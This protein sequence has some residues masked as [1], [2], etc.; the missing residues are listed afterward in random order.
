MRRTLAPTGF[1][2]LAAM[3]ALAPHEARAV[4]LESVW[5]EVATANPTLASRRA[6]VEA[7][8]HRVAPAGAWASPMV[9]IGALNV[10]TNGR[11]DMEPMTMKMLGVSQSVP[12]FGANRLRRSAAQAAASAESAGLEMANVELFAMAWA[13]YSDAYHAARLVSASRTHEIEMAQLVLAARARYRS[14]S[15]RLDDVLRAEAEQA[16]TLSDRAAYEGEWSGA[17]ARLAALMGRASALLADSLEALPSAPATG[18]LTA[19]LA[20]VDEHHPRLR[21]LRTQRDGYRLSARAARRM[22]WPDLQL[23]VSYGMREPIMGEAQ[24]NMWSAMLG[25][26]LPVFAGQREFSEAAEMEAM[27]RAAEAELQAATLDLQ[28]QARALHA[29]ALSGARMV[30]L[31]ADTV[32]T[33][34]RRAVAASWSAYQA[35]GTDLWRV[36]EATH[37]LYGEEVALI[38]AR[39]GL[40]RSEASLLAVTA[41]AELFGLAFPPIERSG[42]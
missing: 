29:R 25:F 13:A 21:E 18:E 39:Q 41:R 9:E 23:G 10:P 5:R 28:Q 42:P 1:L 7:M 40:A 37:A 2:A 4:S 26:M 8:R 16:R 11:F 33:T 36:F 31:L 20:A 22:A 3:L 27:A 17:Q 32:V 24:D 12:V 30:S 19:Y 35:G 38:R 15:G 14:S 34:Q 6:R